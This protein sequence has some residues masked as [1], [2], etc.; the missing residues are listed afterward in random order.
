MTTAVALIVA[1]VAVWTGLF[2][3]AAHWVYTDA[4]EAAE[5]RRHEAEMA[6]AGARIHKAHQD[7]DRFTTDRPGAPE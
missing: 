3:M 2:I 1:L 4:R 6:A 7:R 5:Q